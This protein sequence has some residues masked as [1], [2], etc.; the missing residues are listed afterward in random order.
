MNEVVMKR[1]SYLIAG[2][3]LLLLAMFLFHLSPSATAAETAG[4]EVV[5]CN[6]DCFVISDDPAGVKVRSGPG[7]QYP[8]IATLPTDPDVTV[9]LD[10]TG[11][12]GEWLRV[13]DLYVVKESATDGYEK[14]LDITG[15]VTGPVLGVGAWAHDGAAYV[16]LYEEMSST[17]PVLTKLPDNAGVAII[18]CR[19]KWLKVDYKGVKGWLAPWTYCGAAFTTCI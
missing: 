19:G 7:D 9:S 6:V 4:Y 18:G 13:T 5:P 1:D 16:P 15:W 10:I 17:A 8:V 11:T 14:M 3:L 2:S 12:S